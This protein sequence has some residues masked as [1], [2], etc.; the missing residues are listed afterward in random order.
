MLTLAEFRLLANATGQPVTF[1]QAKAPN[2]SASISRAIVQSTRKSAEAIIQA[3]GVNGISVQV[4]ADDVP[5]EPIKF[6][7]FLL[8]NGDRFVIDTVITHSERTSGVD[9]HYTCY[10]K[11]R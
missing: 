1:T 9:T 3:Y 2:A 6:D 8:A 11:G 5:V 4:A 7:S 10:C